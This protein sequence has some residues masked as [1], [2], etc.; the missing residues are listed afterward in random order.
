MKRSRTGLGLFAAEPINRDVIVIEY[1]GERITTAEGDQRGGKY[2]FTLDDDWVIDGTG[3]KNISRYINHSCKPN[4][5]AEIDEDEEKIYIRAIKRIVP[6]EEITYD[7]GKEYWL[8][9][10]QPCRCAHCA[11]ASA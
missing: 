8:D 5:E 9:H 10:C 7:Y 4:C 2:L 11:P 1:T 6:G 3:R